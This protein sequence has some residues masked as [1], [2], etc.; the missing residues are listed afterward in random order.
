MR[1]E[2]KKIRTALGVSQQDA[3]TYAGISIP[4]YRRVEK[5]DPNV[6]IT[7]LVRVALAFGVSC[8]DLYPPLGVTPKSPKASPQRAQ[9]KFL[10]MA[11][12][13]LEDRLETAH[14][15]KEAEEQADR[16]SSL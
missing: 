14:A 15:Q 12:Q 16:E 9:P 1:S 2:A 10:R 13:A 8:V 11:Q 6:P 3:A 4:T 7:T 5:G